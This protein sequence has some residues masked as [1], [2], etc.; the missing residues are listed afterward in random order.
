MRPGHQRGFSILEIAVV[1]AIL[2]FLAFLIAP[3]LSSTIGYSRLRETRARLDPV[4]NAM[5]AF[6]AAQNRL[7][8]PAIESLPSSSAGYGREAATPGTCTGTTLLAGGAVRGVIPWVS[9]GL[10]G[11]TATDAYGRFFTYIVTNTQTNLTANTLPGMGGVIAVHNATP[12]AAGNQ[13]NAG[14]LAVA[15]VISHGA[16][17]SGAFNP[18]SGARTPAP[19]G[20]D[21]LE[22]ADAANI[23]I[24][25]KAAS[26][27]P[28]NPYDDIVLWLTP[29]DLLAH[30]VPSGVKT[31]QGAMQE[32]LQSIKAAVLSFVAADT[33]DPDGVGTRTR[34]R[35]LPCADTNGDGAPDCPQRVGT[36]PYSALAVPATT[37]T[38]P[39]GRLIRYDVQDPNLLSHLSTGTSGIYSGTNGSLTVRL[40]SDGPDGAQGTAD[41]VAL[42][43]TVAELRGALVAASIAID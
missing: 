18:E 43:L 15:V 7:P 11:D 24:V 32:K 14:N 5:V 8:C 30:L 39:W 20:A 22:N 27:N 38:D 41:D 33:A 9:L 4:K 16:N 3:I 29:G 25:D 1:I 28:A 13:L 17:G 36:V 19:T 2:G 37:A 35:R 26:D 31:P 10:P 34:A 21:E 6:I 12:V 40:S 42:T 23:A